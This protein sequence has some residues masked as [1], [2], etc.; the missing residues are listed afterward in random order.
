[1]TRPTTRAT[2]RLHLVKKNAEPEPDYAELAG[3]E[4]RFRQG[5]D[6]AQLAGEDALESKVR[7]SQKSEAL[8]H[9]RTPTIFIRP[10]R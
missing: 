10:D 5:E 7:S 4:R 2:A 8:S 9:S 1:V 6:R 3:N